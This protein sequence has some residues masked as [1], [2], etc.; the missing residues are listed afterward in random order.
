MTL[1]VALYSAP[2]GVE[3]NFIPTPDDPRYLTT[4]GRTTGPSDHVLNA[5]QIDRDKPSDPKY[6]AD[7]SQLTYL[8][9]L[10][11]QLTGLQDDINE[12]LTRR[13]EL[14]KNKKK[15]GAEEKRIQEEINQLLDGGDGE[16]DAD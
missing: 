11:T 14:A 15:A 5:G 7:G 9:Q 8:S 1:P 4:E 16:E 6:T 12:F 13:M 3:K 2:D 10:R